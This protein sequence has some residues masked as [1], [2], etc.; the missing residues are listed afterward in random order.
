V[1]LSNQTNGLVMVLPG[2]E[3]YPD[4]LFAGRKGKLHRMSIKGPGNFVYQNSDVVGTLNSK[5]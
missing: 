2:D 3:A 1:A 4:P 5:L